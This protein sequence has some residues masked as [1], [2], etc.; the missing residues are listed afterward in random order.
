MKKEKFKYKKVSE[1][2]M[3]LNERLK[4]A[5]QNGYDPLGQLS[6]TQIYEDIKTVNMLNALD[7]EELEGE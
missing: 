3:D 5:L 6:I 1:L 7:I 4:I 2:E